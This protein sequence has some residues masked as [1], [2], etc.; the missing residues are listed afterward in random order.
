[1]DNTLISQDRLD[2]FDTLR[3]QLKEVDGLVAEVGVYKGGSLKVL[4]KLFDDTAIL[5]FDTFEGLP[6]EQWIESEIHEPGDFHD[7]TLREVTEFL[8]DCSNV[9]LKQGLFPSSAKGLEDYRF[10]LV[11]LDMD[12]YSGTKLAIEWFWP[13]MESGGV[14]VFDDFMWPNC[15]GILQALGDH[16]VKEGLKI[17]LATQYQAYIIKP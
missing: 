9:V 15:P 6:K 14:I 11:H 4:A 8:H 2:T 13:R 16:A 3:E 7:T 5:G 10:K 1:M 12:F 17:H